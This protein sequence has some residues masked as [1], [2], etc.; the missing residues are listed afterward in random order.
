MAD[1]KSVSFNTYTETEL[2]L[3]HASW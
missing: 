1:P 2:R 3:P